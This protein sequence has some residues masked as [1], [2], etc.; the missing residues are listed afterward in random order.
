MNYY[1]QCHSGAVVYTTTHRLICMDCGKL[2]CVLATPLQN[3]FGAGFTEEHWRKLFDEDGVLVDANA[4]IPTVEYQ[5]VYATEKVWETDIWENMSSHIEFLS[6]GDPDEI[7]RW[8]AG[9]P[10]IE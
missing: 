7:A 1:C 4:H 8:R 6:R 5:D 9:E 10:S 3:I 2:H